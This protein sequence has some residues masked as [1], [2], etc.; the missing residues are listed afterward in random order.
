MQTDEKRILKA[1]F[2]FLFS[3]IITWFFI[4]KGATFYQNEG[5]MLFSC[6]IAGAKWGIQLVAAYFFLNE[7]RWVF[8]EKLGFVCFVGSCI[9]LPFCL[10]ENLRV[11]EMGF[12][13]SLFAAVLVMIVLYF[14]AVQQAGIGQ[15]WFWNWFLCLILAIL[16]QMVVVF[17]LFG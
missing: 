1:A 12:L 14:R 17:R 8:I 3:T 4:K 16:L 11:T 13:W 2:Y 6:G 5:Q 15:K 9:L 10:F 7:K